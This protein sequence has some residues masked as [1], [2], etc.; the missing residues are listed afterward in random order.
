MR[1]SINIKASESLN[2]YIERLM[3]YVGNIRKMQSSLEEIVQYKLPVGS[4][5][6]PLDQFLGQRIT[7]EYLH[8]INI[9]K[10]GGYLIRLSV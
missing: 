9:R 3:K 1:T 7:M 4:D 5:L 6:V 10:F 8:L 2:M